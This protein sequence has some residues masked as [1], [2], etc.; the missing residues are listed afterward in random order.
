MRALIISDARAGHESQSVAFCELK[1]YKFEILRIKFSYKWL[2]FLSYLLDFLRI[3]LPIFNYSS[4]KFQNF[5]IV[6]SAGS[7]TYYAN[8][9][10]ARKFKAKNVALMAPKGFRNDFDIVFCTHHDNFHAKNATILPVN[11]N[12]LKP[13]NYYTPQKKAIGF[14]IGGSNKSFVMS[15]EIVKTI[16]EIRAKFSD[17]EALITTSPRTPKEIECVLKKENFN[18]FVSYLEDKINPIYDFLK[19]CKYVF[20]TIDSVSM[21]SE[22]VCNLNANVVILELERKD[23]HNKFDDFIQNLKDKKLVEIYQKNE[24]FAKTEKINLAKILKE[25]NI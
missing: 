21:I 23:E 9:Y 18:F 3:Y 20:I 13:T 2:K 11:L 19:H 1:G 14:I 4:L 24:V 8:K 15:E 25:I 12:Y 5:D 17:H 6:V 10:F 7:T 16:K 22:A